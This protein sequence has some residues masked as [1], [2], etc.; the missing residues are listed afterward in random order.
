MQRFGTETV[1]HLDANVNCQENGSNAATSG[2]SSTLQQTV[3]TKQCVNC[4]V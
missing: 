4:L 1:R 2:L 3:A